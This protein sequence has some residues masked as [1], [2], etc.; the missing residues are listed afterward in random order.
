MNKQVLCILEIGVKNLKT[1]SCTLK[2]SSSA[3]RG[4]RFPT[5]KTTKVNKEWNHS[6]RQRFLETFT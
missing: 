1:N 2:I 3:T 6:Q 5:V 4:K